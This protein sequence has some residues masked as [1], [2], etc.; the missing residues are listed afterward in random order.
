[1]VVVAVVTVAVV[2]TT[3]VAVTALMAVSPAA[4]MPAV[5]VI[6]PVVV[7]VLRENADATGQDEN[8]REKRA[9]FLHLKYAP[10]KWL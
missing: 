6:T 2:V 9:E 1:M 3:M 8:E 5:V 4:V 10:S 7:V